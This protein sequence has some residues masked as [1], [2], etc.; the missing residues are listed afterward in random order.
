MLVKIFFIVNFIQKIQSFCPVH[1]TVS[2]NS[3]S[4]KDA[5]L[6]ASWD[7]KCPDLPSK[8]RIYFENPYLKESPALD[9]I[10]PRNF[11]TG[12]IDTKIKLD[13]LE[14]PTKWS[15]KSNQ[16]SQQ[17]PIDSR[18]GTCLNFYALSFNKSN[19]VT[20]F[21]C[22]KINPQWMSNTKE[23]WLF[24]LKELVIPGS[25]CSG[26]YSTERNSRRRH[27]KPESFHQN[28]DIWHQLVFGVRYLEF[29]VG[30]FRSFHKSLDIRSRFWIF[31]DEHE[32]SPIFSVLEDILKF[33]EISNEILIL[34]FINF[35]YGFH[36]SSGAHEIFKKLLQNMFGHIAVMNNGKGDVK[37]YD[38]TIQ[39]IKS[40]SKNIIILYNDEDLT[41][42]SGK[43]LHLPLISLNLI[44]Y[45]I[46]PHLVIY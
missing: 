45:S 26:C 37:S 11:K 23:F 39:K 5:T 17:P 36:E 24:P 13:N 44:F 22:L 33:A 4:L 35:S 1:L 21:N 20:N 15:F 32:V 12:Q 8:V 30:Y 19:H 25:K 28:L 2:S 16:E 29:S 34:D 43:L 42:R 9:E 14:L 38:F 31:N 10:N 18:E 7:P 6:V 27:L 46:R 41:I 3:L 40:M